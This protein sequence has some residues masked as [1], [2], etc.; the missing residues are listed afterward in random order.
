MSIKIRE[1]FLCYEAC[2]K[3]KKFSFFVK[4]TKCFLL[5]RN[6]IEKNIAL[7]WKRGF[8]QNNS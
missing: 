6:S 7:I 4:E 1:N 8:Y 3:F 2:G 5:I